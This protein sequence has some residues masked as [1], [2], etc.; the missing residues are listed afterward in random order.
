[1]ILV[2]GAT[3]LNGSALLRCLSARG[4]AARALVRSPARAAAIS[5]LPDVEIVEGDM[6]RPET[7]GPALRDVDRAMLISSSDPVMLEVQSSFIDAARAAGV[8]HVVKLS[9]IMPEVDSPF[10]FARMHGLIERKLEAS[11]MAFTHLRAGEF[12]PAYFR[13][14]PSIVAR[15]A[16]FLPMEDARIAS[17]DVGD[18]SEI[19]AAT[20]T[21]PGHEG[22]TYPL[23]GPEALTMSEVAERLSAVTGKPIRYVNV[24]PED[25]RKAQLAAGM[26][27]YLV[28]ALAELFAER[29]KG[30]EAQ[31][32]PVAQQILGRP[33]TSF[34]QFAARNAAIFR[35]ETRA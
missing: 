16:M 28:D 27:P 4:I 12:M 19:A 31:V 30:K 3:G 24:A 1:M 35:G 34:A 29:R 10:R 22:K 23:T 17:I 33:P 15:G 14:V 13:Q 9:G 21:A 2:T 25:A 20:L 8:R 11:G 32:S 6:A 26:P 5:T 18:L 7:L